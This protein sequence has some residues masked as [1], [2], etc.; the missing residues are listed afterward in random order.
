[1]TIS[2]MELLIIFIL[3]AVGIGIARRIAPRIAGEQRK[4]VGGIALLL[5]IVLTF[6]GFVSLNSVRFEPSMVLTA[7][8][9][10]LLAGAAGI[11]FL[12]T[13]S[14]PSSD[15][16]VSSTR[17]CPFCAEQIQAEAKICRFCGKTMNEPSLD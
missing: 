17:K 2:L 3:L 10:G 15:S 14:L 8:V 5:G 13:K 9:F 1:M 11:V 12:L 6:Y 4:I 16:Q 7:I